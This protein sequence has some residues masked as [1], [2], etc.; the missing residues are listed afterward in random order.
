MDFSI[1]DTKGKCAKL[2]RL[3]KILSTSK[4]VFEQAYRM[5]SDLYTLVN[6]IQLQYWTCLKGLRRHPA[7]PLPVLFL[8]LGTPVKYKT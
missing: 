3:H 6:F 2:K 5:F 1:R 8:H 7:V 4:L